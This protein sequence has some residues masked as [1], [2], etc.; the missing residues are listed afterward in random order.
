MSVRLQRESFDIGA[1][2]KALRGDN[3]DIGAVVSFTGS[4][5]GTVGGGD[6][7][8][9]TLEHYPGMTESELR[10]IEDEALKRWSLEASLIIHRYGTL[11]PGED[12]VLVATAS[13]HR[14]E[15]F[16][17]AQFIM[18]YLKSRAPFWKNETL[19]DG[20]SGWVDAREGDKSA[21]ERW[22]TS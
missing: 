17:A 11:E 22:K 4:V 7:L 9:M 10:L 6:L 13:P 18:D 15:A 8:S 16:E 2:L 19:R 21:E 5:R 14:A 1:E 20:K 12:I 3:C